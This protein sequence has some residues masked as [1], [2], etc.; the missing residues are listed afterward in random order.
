MNGRERD[1]R[2]VDKSIELKFLTAENAR[3]LLS[4]SELESSSIGSLSVRRGMMSAELVDIVECL[5]SPTDTAP[6]YE[7]LE[8]IGRGGM[9][10]VYRARQ[11]DLDRIVAIKTILLSS[12]SNANVAKRF[13]REAMAVARLQ[14]PNIVQ[15]WNYGQHNGRYF[16]A[17]EYVPGRTCDALIAGGNRLSPATVWSLVRQTA[18][19]LSHAHR[20]DVIH[21]DIKPSN[22]MVMPPPDGAELPPGVDMVKIADFGLA[23]LSDANEDQARIT[24][25]NAIVG[26]PAYM[27]PEQFLGESID[28]RSDIYS[29]GAT[30]MN[31]LT[32]QTPFRG[33]TIPQLVA[34]KQKPLDPHDTGID[35]L[36][37]GHAELLVRMLSPDREDRPQSYS[38]LIQSIDALPVDNSLQ[39]RVTIRRSN[40]PH[41]HDSNAGSTRISDAET[42][43]I[44]SSEIS[45]PVATS[46][47]RRRVFA[48]IP[49]AAVVTAFA[50]YG[51]FREQEPGLRQYRKVSSVSPLFDGVTLA[52]WDVGGTAIG[53][54]NVTRAPDGSDAIA[55]FST[56]GG[57]THRLPDWPHYRASLFVYLT[58]D[59]VVVDIDF[60]FTAG[61]PTSPRGTV[62][63]TTQSITLG[64]KQ[65]DAG[66]MRERQV[67]AAPP[68]IRDRYHVV[69]I[70]RQE[71]DWYIFFEQKFVGSIP[72][73][74]LPSGNAI[75]IVMDGNNASDPTAYIADVQASELTIATE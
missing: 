32:G 28:Y 55:C 31:L 74:A 29:L 8:V 66:D 61:Q 4:D 53:A 58:S 51:W 52:G 22:L 10:V 57:L 72:I 44:D 62:R 73:D 40:A 2:F 67:V 37:T 46:V 25:G 18:S 6:G 69:D 41:A 1:Q 43:A 60:G 70:E 36:P 35:E 63:L 33:K 16:F 3:R 54:W 19:G 26:S 64:T 34:V 7:L 5:L 27:S 47:S 24:T 11:V 56:R 68:S 21:R 45:G 38:E 23:I 42:Q 12:M 48:M 39:D 71:T 15:A 14:H 75:R 17:M 20:H 50:G 65:A 13:E 59:D 9:G 30:A 49:I